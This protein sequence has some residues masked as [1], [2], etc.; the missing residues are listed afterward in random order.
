V[1]ASLVEGA[2]LHDA[3][4]VKTNRIN[5]IFFIWIIIRFIIVMFQGFI[6]L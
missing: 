6:V 4:A 2:F 3:I 1:L 5:K